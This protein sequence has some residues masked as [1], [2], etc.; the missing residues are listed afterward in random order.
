MLSK[1]KGG[2]AFIFCGSGFGSSWFSRWRSGSSLKHCYTKLPYEEFAV[3][4]K[5][6]DCIN[7]KNH[8][9]GPNLL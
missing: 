6:E 2:S 5:K 3:V 4:V 9:A 7:V 8:G 1:Q